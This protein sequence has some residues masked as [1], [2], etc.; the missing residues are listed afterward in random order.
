MKQTAEV[1]AFGWR[2][3]HHWILLGL[4]FYYTVFLSYQSD[5]A[6]AVGTSIM[7]LTRKNASIGD[8]GR[9]VKYLFTPFVWAFEFFLMIVYAVEK[10]HSD[11]SVEIHRVCQDLINL[12]HPQIPRTNVQHNN[13]PTTKD[14]HPI[15]AKKIN[16]THNK[17]QQLR[18][19]LNYPLINPKQLANEKRRG[20]DGKNKPYN[21]KRNRQK[22]NR[23]HR[24]RIGENC[25]K[26]G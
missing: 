19:N 6:H 1:G 4:D 21:K 5:F 15:Y 24:S 16:Q 9:L 2:I 3:K 14:N 22:G 13:T 11:A 17:S 23:L 18:T 10:L 25:D 20:K 7:R 8:D 12:T 26:I